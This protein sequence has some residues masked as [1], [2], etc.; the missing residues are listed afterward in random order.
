MSVILYAKPIVEREIENL[1]QRVKSLI[2]KPTLKVILVGNNPSSILYV[3]NKLSFCKKINANCEIVRVE[4]SISKDDFIKLVKEIAEDPTVTGLLVQLP[5]PDHLKDIEYSSLIP[6]L[7]DV[8]GFTEKNIFSLYND[9]AHNKS[10]ALPPCTPAGIVKMAEYY[11]T[12][13]SG[14]NVVILG[15]SLIVG[16]PL[17]LL[18]T[19]K[20]ATVTLCHS[21]TTNL[22][23][24]TKSADIIIS[25]MGNPH[26]IT[27]DF[28]SATKDQV[29][30]D[31]GISRLNNKTVGDVNFQEVSALVSAITPVPGG[32]GPMTILSL[33]N[34]LVTTTEY[35]NLKKSK[36]V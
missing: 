22:S 25:A 5:V 28:I 26:F 15:R 29:I 6:P 11:G 10:I 33:A 32:I 13:F 35:Q 19:N 2:L 34:N 36:D 27:K 4:E 8:D 16:K 20:N 1:K 14:K 7:K 31:V 18:L 9:K 12:D 3:N 24:I 21:K 30:F 17:S 23:K